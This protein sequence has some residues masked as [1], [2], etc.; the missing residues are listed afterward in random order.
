MLILNNNEKLVT[1]K[2]EG[3]RLYVAYQ[4]TTS[5]S[6]IVRRASDCRSTPFLLPKSYCKTSKVNPSSVFVF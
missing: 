1:I 3:K 5:D 4:A 2:G 6:N